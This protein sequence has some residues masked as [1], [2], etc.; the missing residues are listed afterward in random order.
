MRLE[1]VGDCFESAFEEA[2][3]HEEF[4]EWRKWGSARAFF[5]LD[6]VDEARLVGP[7]RFEMTIKRLGRELHG[8][9]D[10]C[11]IFA[12]VR[13][14]ADKGVKQP[15][16]HA[17]LYDLTVGRLLDLKHELEEAEDSRAS[18]LQAIK[19]EVQLRNDF[20]YWLRQRSCSIYSV[21]Q[22]EELCRRKASRHS[23]PFRARGRTCAHRIKNSSQIVNMSTHR[24]A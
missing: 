20:A 2:G 8:A 7:K 1:F 14:F 16:N 19:R 24:T 12:A 6:S 9:L 10:R 17:E 18:I 11:G 3:T 21:A 5:F 13:E 23:S 4:E 15:G 22:E